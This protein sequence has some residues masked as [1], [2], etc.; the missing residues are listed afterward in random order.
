MKGGGEPQV[1]PCA[2]VF[3]AIG[4]A[5]RLREV[6]VELGRPQGVDLRLAIRRMY[7]HLPVP[8]FP[9]N[10]EVLCYLRKQATRSLDEI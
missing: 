5:D 9:V 4:F 8:I 3:R 10:F 1:Y 6:S 2:K 7:R